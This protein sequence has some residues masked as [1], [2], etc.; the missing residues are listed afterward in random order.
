M[1]IEGSGIIGQNHSKICEHKVE[2]DRQNV[3][4]KYFGHL[5]NILS[6][7]LL[8]RIFVMDCCSAITYQNPMKV[9]AWGDQPE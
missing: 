3:T 9:W 5:Y 8:L 7:R 2:N 1:E 6:V 4:N